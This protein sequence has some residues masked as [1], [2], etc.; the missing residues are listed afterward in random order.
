MRAELGLDSTGKAKKTRSMY[1]ETT[2]ER[3]AL[4]SSVRNSTWNHDEDPLVVEITA[5]ERTEHNFIK[6]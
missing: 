6:R 2:R 3:E 1:A 5:P 4:V